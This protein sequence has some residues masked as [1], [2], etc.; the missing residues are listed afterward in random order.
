M[1]REHVIGYAL[2]AAIFA[3]AAWAATTA[4]MPFL[5]R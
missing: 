4:P 1:K 5:N 2:L 3:V